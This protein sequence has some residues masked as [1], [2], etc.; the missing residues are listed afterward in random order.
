MKRKQQHVSPS[1]TFIATPLALL[2]MIMT[3]W[4]DL[5]KAT[6][7]A[8]PVMLMLI[9]IGMAVV[10]ISLVHWLKELVSTKRGG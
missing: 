6:P 10:G 4:A 2:I 1:W 5:N 3:P 8:A 9:S 7:D